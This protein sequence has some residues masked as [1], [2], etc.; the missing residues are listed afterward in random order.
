[1]KPI[2][3]L[4]EQIVNE[5]V[6]EAISEARQQGLDVVLRTLDSADGHSYVAQ[7]LS[8]SSVL[9]SPAYRNLNEP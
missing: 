4:Y 3:G 1:M 9:R 2:V 7:Y 6:G 8:P 5:V